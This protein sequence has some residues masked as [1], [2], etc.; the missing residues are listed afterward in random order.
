MYILYIYIYIYVYNYIK[1]NFKCVYSFAYYVVLHRFLACSKKGIEFT[2]KEVNLYSESWDVSCE[3]TS[4][5]FQR[6][7]E[8]K[9]HD[10]KKTLSLNE[11]RNYIIALSKPMGEAV[12]L[13]TMNLGRINDETEKCKTF[14]SDISTFRTQLKFKAFDLIVE[15]LNYPMT[16]CAAEK[17]KTYAIVGEENVRRTVYGQICH[18]HC[19]LSGISIETI[20][21][22]KLFGCCAMVDGNCSHCSHSYREHMHITYKTTLV[23]TEF[24]TKEAQRIIMEKEDMKSRKEACIATLRSQ[25]KEYEQEKD[26]IYECASFFGVF[27]KNHAMIPYN[28]SFGDYVDMLIKDEEAKK[29]EIRDDGKIRK[30]KEEKL[31]YETKKKLIKRTISSSSEGKFK[32]SHLEEINKRKKKLCSLKHNGRILREALGKLPSLD[33]LG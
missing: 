4:K 15:P 17:C 31:T 21:N 28:D 22:E 27:L 18:D 32:T 5:L 26:Y 10:T 2:P 29:E 8:M 1:I 19:F 3:T 6:V 20:N 30:L 9:P 16:V 23:V 7:M 14:D 24:L 13:I 11:A 12:E 25:S 33:V